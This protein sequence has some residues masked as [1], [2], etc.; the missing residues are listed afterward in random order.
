MGA[1]LGLLK[2]AATLAV[3][4]LVIYGVY[5]VLN[6]KAN[7]SDAQYCQNNR[8]GVPL[9]TKSENLLQ[10]V[11]N[12]KLDLCTKYYDDFKDKR[13]DIS[14]SSFFEEMTKEEILS[15]CTQYCALFNALVKCTCESCPSCHP[16]CG[17]NLQDRCNSSL[18]CGT[19]EYTVYPATV[20][21]STT[22]V[23]SGTTKN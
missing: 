23:A 21:G 6:R 14:K 17:Y 7:E 1:V 15:E 12:C 18:R 11:D 5:W 19:S 4:V 16:W 2:L 3:V 22:S 10:Y 9:D 8:S 13:D 20:S